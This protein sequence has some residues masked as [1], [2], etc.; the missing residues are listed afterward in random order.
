LL[1]STATPCRAATGQSVDHLSP[2][3]V[4]WLD[5]ARLEDAQINRRARQL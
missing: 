2:E 4:K 1:N 3:T 5:D